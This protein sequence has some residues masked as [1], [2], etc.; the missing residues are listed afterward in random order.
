MLLVYPEDKRGGK[1]SQ[2]PVDAG[3]DLK[4]LSDVVRIPMCT[5]L[6][7]R[8]LKKNCPQMLSDPHRYFAVTRAGWLLCSDREH[9]H[10]AYYFQRHAEQ[11]RSIEHM[12][13]IGGRE[14]VC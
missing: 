12:G 6:R 5:Y 2:E 11:E 4:L 13:K 7:E 3:D 9:Q 8:L 14:D 1:T 10:N